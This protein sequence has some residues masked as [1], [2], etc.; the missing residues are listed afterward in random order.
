MDKIN[1]KKIINEEI[2]RFLKEDLSPEEFDTIRDRMFATKSHSNNNQ[3]DLEL[4]QYVGDIKEL[5]QNAPVFKNP[6]NWSLYPNSVRFIMLENG[7]KYTTTDKFTIHEQILEFLVSKNIL[8]SQDI[9]NWKDDFPIKF[10]CYIK[11]SNSLATLSSSY[12]EIINQMKESPE[13]FIFKT[14]FKLQ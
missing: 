13:S 6:K 1:I 8:Q 10:G 4:G 2:L 11:S 9:K 14:Y 12:D 7:D 5:K 3:Y